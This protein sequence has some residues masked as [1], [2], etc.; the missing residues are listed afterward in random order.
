MEYIGHL[1]KAIDC[2]HAGVTDTRIA[3][4]ANMA[5]SEVSLLG[6]IHIE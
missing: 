5:I 2:R 4:V 3:V 6:L 1:R